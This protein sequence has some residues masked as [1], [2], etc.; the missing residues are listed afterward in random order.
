MDAINDLI[1]A[2]KRAA[3]TFDG[4]ARQLA[5]AGLPTRASPD[6]TSPAHPKVAAARDVDVAGQL[7]TMMV[8][9]DMHHVTT[10]ALR[11]AFS[12]Y[13]DSLDLIRP[14]R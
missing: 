8:A 10:A 11:S 5:G 12:L 6:P 4:A 7:T 13:Q 9:A 3:A 1:G 2:T 14:D